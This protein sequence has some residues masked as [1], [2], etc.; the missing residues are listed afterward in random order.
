MYKGNSVLAVQHRSSRTLPLSSR[1]ETTLWDLLVWAFKTE[2]VLA[3]VGQDDVR[4][5]SRCGDSART[6]CEALQLGHHIPGPVV[7]GGLEVHEDALLVYNVIKEGF[8]GPDA[9]VLMDA[10]RRGEPPTWSPELL[11]VKVRPVMDT[12]RR[13]PKP[14]VW[15]RDTRYRQGFFCPIIYTGY[16]EEEKIEQRR[17]AQAG[18]DRFVGL[19]RYLLGDMKT[20]VG[21]RLSRWHV[22]GLGIAEKP[23]AA[24]PRDPIAKAAKT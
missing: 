5:I 21:A 3:V 16:T 4:F 6:I 9:W 7:T 8:T 10:A 19:M 20:G 11:D 13:K 17:L 18:Y 15:Y 23:W 12:S 2:C 24:S 22:S 14:E 1:R